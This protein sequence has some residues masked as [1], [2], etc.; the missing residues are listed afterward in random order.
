[1]DE[2]V[3][4]IPLGKVY[5]YPRSVRSKKAVSFIKRFVSRHMKT[6]IDHVRLSNNVNAE[7]W[8]HGIQKPPRKVKV[9]VVRHEGRVYVYT[10]DEE[11]TVIKEEKQ[12]KKEKEKKSTKE[13]EEKSEKKQGEKKAVSKKESSEGSKKEQKKRSS[14][15]AKDRK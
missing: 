10:L 5:D 3:Y 4:T 13:G 1:M 14:E 6:D 8:R 9:K 7:V 12:T 2:R 15:E 11:V